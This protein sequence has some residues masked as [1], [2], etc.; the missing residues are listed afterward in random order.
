MNRN[1]KALLDKQLWGVN[2]E[3]PGL[4]GLALVGVFLGGL[5]IG[6]F[7]FARESRHTQAASHNI[8]GTI[9][10]SQ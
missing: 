3:P 9:S 8:T 2:P 5:V 6:S 1:D 10:Q 4:I 7:L